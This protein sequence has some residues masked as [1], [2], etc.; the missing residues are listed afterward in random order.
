MDVSVTTLTQDADEIVQRLTVLNLQQTDHETNDNPMIPIPTQKDDDW[1]SQ[2]CKKARTRVKACD[3]WNA[4]SI[5]A[6]A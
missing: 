3:C 5:A 4:S 1:T 2:L 6:N